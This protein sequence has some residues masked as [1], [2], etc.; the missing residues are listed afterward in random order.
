[1]KKITTYIIAAALISSAFMGCKKDFLDI[2]ENPNAPQKVDIKDVLP[3][4]ELAIGHV[5]GNN[6]QIYGGL[7]A[8]YWTQNP[9]SSQ[10]KTIEQ[11]SPAADDFDSPWRICYSDALQDLNYVIK[12]GNQEGKTQ[13]VACAKILQAYTYQILTDNFG[14]IPFSE[15]LRNEE[16]ILAPKYDSQKDV[17]DGIIVLINEGLA[18]IDPSATNGPSTNDLLCGGDMNK[19]RKFANTLKLRVYLR[20]AYIDPAKA[21]AGISAMAGVPL[22]GSGE[23][24]K[25]NYSSTPGG[26][27]PLYSVF[28]EISGTQNL[29]ASSTC[30]DVMYG[31]G[32]SYDDLRITVFYDTI[33]GPDYAGNLQGD[34]NSGTPVS[35]LSLPHPN[36]GANNS[37]LGNKPSKAAAAPVKF[38]S[39]YESLFLQAEAVARGYM[40]GNDQTFYED[41][42]T[43]NYLAYGLTIGDAAAYFA[44]PTFA[45]PIAGTLNQKIEAIIN[46]KYFS[47]CGNQNNEAW[48]EYRRTGYPSFLVESAISNIGSGRMPNRMF[49]PGSELTRNP[50]TPPQHV[51]YDR[52]WWDIN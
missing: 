9:F 44:N 2:N 31:V 16:G 40:A 42:I 29:V 22:L 5:M 49:Y 15:A 24:I 39:D 38:M 6:F 50:K 32:A 41:G 23:D 13:Y 37:T 30:L 47:M 14:D 4:A 3:S 27:N 28:S 19:W 48:V 20:L 7:W 34:I 1:M 18:L 25:I 12:K 43:A 21:S 36:T 17:Y 52:V 46:Q 8:Q 35:Q 51:I 26:T 11:Y 45:Y 10:Y 33:K